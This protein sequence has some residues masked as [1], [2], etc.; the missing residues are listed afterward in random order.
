MSLKKFGFFNALPAITRK[1][2]VD[3]WR[4]FRSLT[5]LIT[6]RCNL[7]CIYCYA[8]AQKFG[9]AMNSDFA[10]KT[11]NW[12]ENQLKEKTLRISFHGGGEPTLEHELVKNVVS[13]AYHLI[14]KNG[15]KIRFQITT[16]GT[17]KISVTNW[18]IDNNFGISISADGPPHIQNRNR[19]FIN[20]N[21]S[22]KVVERTILYLVRKNYA[23]TVRLTFSTVDDIGEIV[24]YFGDLGVKSLHLEPLFPHGR[25]YDKVVFGRKS[26]CYVYSPNGKEFAISFF[27]AMS[28]A[29][30][31]GIRITN[32]HL[33]HLTKGIGYFCGSACGRSMIVTS[34]EFISGCLEVVD[35]QDLDFNTFKLGVFSHNQNTFVVDKIALAQLQ[36][37]HS[38][39]LPYC[40]KCFARY[41]CSGGCAVKAIRASGSFMERDIPYCVFTK[42]LIPAVI[43]KIANLSGI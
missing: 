17:A 19:P 14:K 10:L 38:D 39:V 24:R 35:A 9:K 6:R 15:K 32:S 1:D 3:A 20:G 21:G 18:L 11:L 27:N 29:R 28:F 30:E 12:F 13:R 22:S 16:N 40:R 26:G 23:F 36:K 37:R 25:N 33:G 4:G 34:D 31:Y 2:S 7:S 43:I 8:A 41:V 5:L 42:A